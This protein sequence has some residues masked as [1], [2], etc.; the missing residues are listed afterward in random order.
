MQL[1]IKSLSNQAQQY[2]CNLFERDSGCISRGLRNTAKDPRLLLNTSLNAK[3][4]F[5]TTVP[6][7]GILLQ[8]KLNRLLP[9]L[10]LSKCFYLTKMKIAANFRFLTAASF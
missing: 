5:P 9:S 6:D 2:T 7:D 8:M 10:V 1:V 4:V 3:Q